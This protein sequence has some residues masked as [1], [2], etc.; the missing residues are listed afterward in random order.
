LRLS[1]GGFP[2]RIQIRELIVTIKSDFVD[3]RGLQKNR[4][5]LYRDADYSR[6]KPLPRNS[7]AKSPPPENGIVFDSVRRKSGTNVCIFWP[8]KVPL[9]VAQGDHFE[10][11]WDA[12]GHRRS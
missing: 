8:S 11:Q 2:N 6:R 10:Y 3:V 7:L 5:E 9:P 1:A 12:A 4:P